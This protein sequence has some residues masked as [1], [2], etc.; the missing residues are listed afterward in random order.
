MSNKPSSSPLFAKQLALTRLNILPLE[1]VR[2][3]KDYA[4]NNIES[5]AKQK[6]KKLIALFTPFYILNADYFKIQSFKSLRIYSEKCV[7]SSIENN[8]NKI[9]NFVFCE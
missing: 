3:I 8:P 4:F 6:K 2:I 1:V 5:V 7:L 9:L